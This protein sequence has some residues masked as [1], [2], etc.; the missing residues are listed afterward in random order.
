M[1]LAVALHSQ[2]A[3]DETG[4]ASGLDGDTTLDGFFSFLDETGVGGQVV[5]LQLHVLLGHIGLERLDFLHVND[6]HCSQAKRSDGRL[7]GVDV[8]SDRERLGSNDV[9]FGLALLANDQRREHVVVQVLLGHEV[10]QAE[11]LVGGD[12][13]E[14]D[15]SVVGEVGGGHFAGQVLLADDSG[16]NSGKV[17]WKKFR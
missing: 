4:P 5:S 7:T 2:R 16:A 17:L 15:I 1:I 11:L 13:G 8:A 12:F 10:G 6:T 3:C 9:P 14:V